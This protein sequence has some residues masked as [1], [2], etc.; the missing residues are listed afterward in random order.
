LGE[1]CEAKQRQQG[2]VSTQIRVLRGLVVL[3]TAVLVSRPLETEILWFGLGLE[4]L[5]LAV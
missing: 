3:E 2:M 5:V 4:A 1:N